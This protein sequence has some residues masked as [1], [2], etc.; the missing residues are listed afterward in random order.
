MNTAASMPPRVLIAESDPW[1]RDL[2]SQMLLSVRC[3][4]RLHACATGPAALDHLR[5]LPS[6]VIAARELPGISGLELLRSVRKSPRQAAL[7][8]ILLSERG[9]SASVREVVPLAPTAY[10]TKP[11][12]MA[13]LKARLHSLLVGNGEAVVCRVPQI[14]AGTTLEQYLERRRLDGDGGPLLCDVQAAVK[15]ALGAEGLNLKMLE[16]N[17]RSDPQVTAVLVCAANSAAKQGA[18]PVLT[19]MQ[20]LHALGATQSMNLLLGLAFKPSARLSDPLLLAHAETYWNRSTHAAEFA[21][22][23]ARQQNLDEW[24]CHCA[25]L[26]HCLGDLALLRVLQEW[27]SARGG[28]DEASVAKALRTFGAPYGSE[29]RRRWRLPLELRE[30]IAA[31]YQLGGGVYSRDKL[32]VNV[33]V[34][35]AMLSADDDVAQIAQGKPARLLKI[36]IS[37]LNWW[38]GAPM[39]R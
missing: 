24:R 15:R 19:L 36:G 30:M 8:F 18:A 26:L 16:A 27:Q 12:D 13:S 28:L 37:Q 2:L 14:A 22:S 35:M 38:R 5:E 34:Q 1:I 9:D 11:L 6:L 25:G 29:L 21:R 32:I 20:A 4:A 7:P 39:I 31:A 3:D 17:V 10:L 23:I 33:A